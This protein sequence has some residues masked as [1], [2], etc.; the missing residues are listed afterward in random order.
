MRLL[1]IILVILYAGLNI[2]HARHDAW[3][4]LDGRRIY[5]G[6]NGL[7]QVLVLVPVYF[8][9]NDWFFIIGLLSVRRIVFDTALN[10]FRGL[11][12]DYISSTTTSIIDRLSYN[13][14]KR[15]GYVVYYGLFLVVIMLSI[16]F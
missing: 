10:I 4:I 2:L 8:Y 1:E 14:Q 16:I 12:F 5:H 7:V 13:F 15:Y 6:I 11:R 3:R 9:T